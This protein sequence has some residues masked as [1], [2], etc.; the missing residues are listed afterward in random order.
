MEEYRQG[1]VKAMEVDFDNYNDI[2]VKQLK[3][4]L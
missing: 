3:E 4:I 2:C 1:N